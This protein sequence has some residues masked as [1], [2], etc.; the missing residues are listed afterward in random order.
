MGQVVSAIKET[1]DT[2]TLILRVQPEYRDYQ[3]GQFITIDPHQFPEL[4]DLVRYFEYHKGK[5]EVVRAYSLTSAP[6]EEHLAITIKPEPYFPEPGAYPPVL[7]P[8]LASD[9]LVGKTLELVGY[10]GAYVLSPEL[11]DASVHAI[12]LV[13]GSGIVPSFSILKD[14][15]EGQKNLHLTHTLLYVNK[16][17]DDIIF[18][19]EIEALANKYPDRLKVIHFLTR[20]PNFAGLGDSFVSGRPH[21]DHVCDHIS[22][23]SKTLVFACG[24]ANSKWHKKRALELGEELKPR[25]MEWVSQTVEHLQIEKKH[26]KREVYG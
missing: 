19:K 6:H 1:T 4:A 16:S 12:H 7:S 25:F 13:A 24:P 9:L 17:F 2:W 18:I 5:R 3:A 10:S 14:Q 11:A 20:Q 23:V 21:L 15:L 8:L 22:D 26:F